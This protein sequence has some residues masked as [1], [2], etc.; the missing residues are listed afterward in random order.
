MLLVDDHAMV[1]QGLRSLLASYADT[2]V[3]AEA[4]NGVEALCAV[5]QYRPAVVIMDINMLD[6]NGIEATGRIKTRYPDI[7]IISISV[8]AAK[9]NQDAM[10]KAG[11]S[12]LLTKEAAVNQ[13]YGAIQEVMNRRR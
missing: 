7:K 5:D 8:N 3:V 4:G 11:A 6:M 1:R 10:Q 12:L 9:E 13:L 2:E